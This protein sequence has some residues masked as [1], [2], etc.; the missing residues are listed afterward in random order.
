MDGSTTGP[1]VRESPVAANWRGRAWAA[2][3][4]AA[5]LGVLLVAAWLQPAGSGVGTHEQLG[6][7]PCGWYQRT[8]MPCLTC[9]VTTAMAWAAD[10]HLGRAFVVQPAGAVLALGLAVTV[11]LAGYAAVRGADLSGLVRG[12]VRGRVLLAAL[13]LVIGAWA[14][15]IIVMSMEASGG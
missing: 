6:L 8:G 9:G 5:A 12:L 10:G 2:G 3:V 4:A 14:Y 15:K 13:I 1:Q 11:L 7:P